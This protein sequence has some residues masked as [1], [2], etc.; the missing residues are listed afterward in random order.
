M[1]TA[2]K[3]YLRYRTAGYSPNVAHSVATCSA[4]RSILPSRADDRLGEYK[5]W[6]VSGESSENT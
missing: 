5:H 3:F 1:V 2:A 6:N 4:M